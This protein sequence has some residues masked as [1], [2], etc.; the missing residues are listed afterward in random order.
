MVAYLGHHLPLLKRTAD[1]NADLEYFRPG[2]VFG[3]NVLKL[4]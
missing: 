3:L 1:L 4:V 2:P